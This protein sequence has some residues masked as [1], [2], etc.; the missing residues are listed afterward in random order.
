MSPFTAGINGTYG[1]V[2]R[3]DFPYPAVRFQEPGEHINAIL[4]KEK[5][6]WKNLTIEEKKALYRYS[7]RQTFAEFEAPRGDWKFVVGMIGFA[8]G[9]VLWAM[10]GLKTFVLPPLPKS[11]SDEA[12]EAQMRRMINARTNPIEGIASKWDYEKNTWK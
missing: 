1:Y 11:L 4:Q 6:D 2:D 7:Y 9:T 3:A 5:G 12:K 8:M 10:M